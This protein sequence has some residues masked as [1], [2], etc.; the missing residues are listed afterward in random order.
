MQKKTYD[1]TV[2]GFGLTILYAISCMAFIN[3]LNI[4]GFKLR[5]A[6][7]VILFGT[8]CI[9]SVGVMTLKEWG[10]KLLIILNAVMFF[11]LAVRFIPQLDLVP[12][13]YLFLS[14]IILLYFTQSKVKIQ[15]LKGEYDPWHRSVLIVDDDEMVPKMLRPILFSHGYSVLTA[16][17]GEDGL[18]IAKMQKPDLIILDVILPGIKGREVCQRIKE[19]PETQHIPVIFLT[20]KNS[21]EDFRAEED[22][23]SAGHLTKPVDSKNLIDMI[24]KTLD[25]KKVSKNN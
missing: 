11:F 8:L 6:V 24:Q 21:Q 13:A 17:S 20:A 12:L 3:Y 9:G 16:S 10:R 19:D 25:P 14:L 15:F 4:P 7:Y 2:I 22:A 23:G 1:V 18:Q 5:T